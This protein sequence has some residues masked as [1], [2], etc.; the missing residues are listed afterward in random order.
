M[1]QRVLAKE[2]TITDEGSVIKFQ[3]QNHSG[4]VVD[5]RIDKGP[6][7]SFEANDENDILVY[8]ADRDNLIFPYGGVIVPASTDINDLVG[9]LKTMKETGGSS[10]VNILLESIENAVEA[11]DTGTSTSVA[12]SLGSVLLLAANADRKGESPIRQDG[13]GIL[14]IHEGAG[15]ATLNEAVKLEQDDLWIVKNYTGPV[16][17]IWDVVNGFARVT[18]NTKA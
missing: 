5:Y 4:N 15:P 1:R 3:G 13:T 16:F 2:I 6:N 18:E 10:G 17:G 7:M 9:Q 12:S 11:A 8:G 14:F